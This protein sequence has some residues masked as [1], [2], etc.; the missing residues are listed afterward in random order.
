[1]TSI[2]ITKSNTFILLLVVL[3]RKSAFVLANVDRDRAFLHQIVIFQMSIPFEQL[4][5]FVIF[6]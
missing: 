2:A 3:I 1:M 5:P 4:P 6:M